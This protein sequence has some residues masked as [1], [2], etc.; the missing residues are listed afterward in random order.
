[1]PPFAVWL[2]ELRER[3]EPRMSQAAL[4]AAA[5]KWK[6]RPTIYQARITDWELGKGLP[7][8]RQLACLC[9][10]LEAPRPERRKGKALWEAAQLDGIP[11]DGRELF[12]DTSNHDTSVP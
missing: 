12:E 9:L 11:V 10:A 8:L 2:R 7:N 5:N 6:P 4:A 3:R 1:M